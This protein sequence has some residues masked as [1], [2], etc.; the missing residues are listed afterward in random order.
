MNNISPKMWRE[1]EIRLKSGVSYRKIG[2][3]VPGSN[4]KIIEEV[5][6][7]RGAATPETKSKLKRDPL[8]ILENNG[9]IDHT[10]VR[11]AHCIRDAYMLI[12]QEVAVRTSKLDQRIDKS[13]DSL[14][15]E[16]VREI[17]L[18]NQYKAWHER[19]HKQKVDFQGRQIPLWVSPVIY[20]L[21]DAVSLVDADFNY[22]KR[23]GYCRAMLIAGL[24]LY[25]DMF[26]P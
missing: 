22:N 1:I 7:N 15:H 17:R 8:E 20:L 3:E 9:S 12:T 23:K 14:D 6:S 5:N 11:A 19:C 26:R 18:I 21:T 4:K 2:L 10:R 16:T 13:G 25:C 24:D